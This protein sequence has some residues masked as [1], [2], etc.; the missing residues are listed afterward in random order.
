MKIGLVGYQGGG[1]SV[2]FELLTGAKPDIAKAHSGQVAEAIV[3]DDRYDRLVA[4]HNP[5]KEVPAKIQVFDTPGLSRDQQDANAQKLGIIREA[6]VLVHVVGMFAGADAVSDAA[7]FEDDLVLADLQVVN[8]RAERLK[9]DV[10]KP[11]PDREELQKELEAITP[12]VQ[13]LEN[14]QPVRV[15][16]LNELQEKMMRSFS[17][18]TIKPQLLVL[19]TA[20]SEVDQS[21]VEK[22]ESEGHRVVAAPFGLELE[23]SALPDEERTEFASEMGLGEPSRNRLLRSIFE[24]TDQITFYTSGEKEVHA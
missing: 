22:L 21:V 24:V 14:G 8:N 10:T 23:L 13:C 17:L 15:L 7:A 9:K 5:K 6:Q 1:K 19:N 2:I 16:E 20:D 12:V 3:P 18:L 11:R 4:H